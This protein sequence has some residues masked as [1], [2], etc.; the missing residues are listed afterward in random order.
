MQGLARKFTAD[1]QFETDDLSG[2]LP[3]CSPSAAAVWGEFA[4]NSTRFAIAE[5]DLQTRVYSMQ[6]RV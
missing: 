3:N 4:D 6:R 5:L 1:R 2:R